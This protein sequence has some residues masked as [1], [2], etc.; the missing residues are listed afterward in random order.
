MMLVGVV[1][2]PDR[3]KFR[4]ATFIFAFNNKK[5]VH[6]I[7]DFLYKTGGHLEKYDGPVYSNPYTAVARDP[8]AL[9]TSVHAA[10]ALQE[11]S[12]L[13]RDMINSGGVTTVPFLTMDRDCVRMCS[14]VG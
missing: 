9:I 8:H 11:A 13:A 2:G 6:S 1:R 14:M 10:K 12:I 3:R 5:L 4:D 7:G